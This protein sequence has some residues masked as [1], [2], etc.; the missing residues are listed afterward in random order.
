M[1]TRWQASQVD[2]VRDRSRTGESQE[3]EVVVLEGAVVIRVNEDARHSEEDLAIAGLW[4][5]IPID[6]KWPVKGIS[7]LQASK[8]Q[9]IQW[10][11]I[12]I[13][14]IMKFWILKAGNRWHSSDTAYIL[15]KCGQTFVPRLT[16]IHVLCTL[17]W[18]VEEGRIFHLQYLDCSKLLKMQVSLRILPLSIGVLLYVTWSMSS[19]LVLS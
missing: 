5:Q 17:K 18:V 2:S 12:N 1:T 4:G 16:H 10:P 9:H 3:G 19:I 8:L 13:N 11:K 7:N 15:R 14:D 6:F